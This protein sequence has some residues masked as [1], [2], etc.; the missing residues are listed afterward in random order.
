[1]LHDTYIQIPGRNKAEK[2]LVITGVI[3][4]DSDEKV[5]YEFVNLDTGEEFEL[6]RARLRDF[7]KSGALRRYESS[8]LKKKY[9][10]SYVPSDGHETILAYLEEYGIFPFH[11]ITK[12]QA[13]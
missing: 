9:T 3:N 4:P 10:D 12:K 8:Y 11:L 7:I 2:R 1:M 6:S 13:A 5:R